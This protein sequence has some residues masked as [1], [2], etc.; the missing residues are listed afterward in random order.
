MLPTI[1]PASGKQ[2]MSD[3]RDGAEIARVAL[4]REYVARHNEG[5]STRDFSRLLDLFAPHG[6]L[7]F[8]GA[9]VGPFVGKD[10]VAA[11]FR[12]HGPSDALR[13]LDDDGAYAW[14]ADP[15]RR[16][17]RIEVVGEAGRIVRVLVRFE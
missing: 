12:D 15:E 7:R 4:L 5:V 6:E 11:A 8:E 2:T 13:L 10:A 17:G 16:A 3:E 14:G 1:A 9:P